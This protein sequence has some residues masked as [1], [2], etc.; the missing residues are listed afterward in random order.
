MLCTLG[1]RQASSTSSRNGTGGGAG[2]DSAAVPRTVVVGVAHHRP[3]C[4]DAS[5]SLPGVGGPEQGTWSRSPGRRIVTGRWGADPGRVGCAAVAWRHGR[6]RLGREVRRCRAGLV[7]DAQPVRRGRADRPARP[8]ARSTWRPGE[9]RNAIWLASRGWDVTAVDFS[10]VG[11][12]KGRR[13]ASGQE[14]L[15]HGALGLRRRDDVGGRRRPTTLAVIAYLQLPADQ[16]RAAVRRAFDALRPGG[17]FLLV[18]HDST[19]LTEG[20]GGPQDPAVLMTADGRARGPRRARPSRSSTPI[21]SRA[22]S[23][24]ATARTRQG[25]LGLPG[26]GGAAG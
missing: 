18:A 20:T 7:G 5:A 3:S 19:N 1:A 4:A 21:G 16:R 25:R 11:L 10:E 14:L 22:P 23:T 2:L 12:D 15:G 6:E 13:L 9:G 8:A 26:A 17:T 24:T